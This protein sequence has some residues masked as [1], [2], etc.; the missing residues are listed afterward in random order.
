MRVSDVTVARVRRSRWI[1]ALGVAGA[2]AA[3]PACNRGAATGN[4]A[5]G[6]DFEATKGGPVK[7]ANLDFTLKDVNGRD[8]ALAS[9]AGKPLLINF[10]ATWC[11]PCKAEMPWFVE[12]SDKYK[13]KG[14][15]VVGVSVDD[16]PE[17]IRGFAAEHHVTYPLLV[18]RDRSDIAKAYDAEDV[19]P[20]SWLVRADGTVQ[21]KVT[22]IHGKDWFEQQ[23]QAMF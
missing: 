10:W 19:I 3:W 15:A 8:V 22:G 21:A 14:L 1:L 12:F 18:G 11:G 6:G 9:L 13:A 4:P 20:V 16:P 23:L 5:A 17:D 2:L 7:R